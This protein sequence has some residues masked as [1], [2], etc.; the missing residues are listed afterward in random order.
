MPGSAPGFSDRG[1][2]VTKECRRQLYESI[3]KSL[4]RL[5]TEH[6]NDNPG[7][8]NTSA[9]YSRSGIDL[10]N[11]LA[12][13]AARH[14]PQIQL[15]PVDLS[16]A[17]TVACVSDGP[18]P[19]VKYYDISPEFLNL[20]RFSRED[21]ILQEPWT[22]PKTF[23]DKAHKELHAMYLKA[24][25][26]EEQ[27]ALVALARKDGSLCN[28][29]VSLIP[30]HHEPVQ[31]EDVETK[32]SRPIEWIVGFLAQEPETSVT[33]D[34][35]PAEHEQESCCASDLSDKSNTIHFVSSRGTVQYVSKSVEH[36]LGYTADEVVGR[37][38][39]EICHPNDMV[40]LMRELKD[41][42]N[43]RGPRRSLDGHEDVLSDL[44]LRRTAQPKLVH[45]NDTPTTQ[46]V[47][48]E[49]HGILRMNHK[50]STVIWME[51]VGRLV[52]QPS[53]S[54]RKN[55]TVVAVTGKPRE[56]VRKAAAEA[57]TAG[58]AAETATPLTDACPAPNHANVAP[59]AW[60]ALSA[61]G[62]ILQC[63][64]QNANGFQKA[65]SH[66][67]SELPVR[68]GYSLPSLMNKEAITAVQ[69]TIRQKFRPFCIAHWIGSTPV[70]TTWFPISPGAQMPELARLGASILVRLESQQ[71]GFDHVPNVI[72][73]PGPSHAVL[74]SDSAF[75]PEHSAH[76]FPQDDNSKMWWNTGDWSQ[77]IPAAEAPLAPRLAQ[78]PPLMATTGSPTV[79]IVAQSLV[80]DAF[81]MPVTTVAPESTLLMSPSTFS[82][83]Q[84]PGS[85][86]L[87]TTTV[88]TSIQMNNQSDFPL[89]STGVP[90]SVSLPHIPGTAAD[91]INSMSPHMMRNEAEGPVTDSAPMADVMSF[92]PYRL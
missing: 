12:R 13:V 38:V 7:H 41:L 76:D 27:K 92:W 39:E 54:G 50:H 6:S 40:A 86:A 46:M 20:Y 62:V 64:V 49:V 36:L 3:P 52:L 15:G 37:H 83:N 51:I 22:V 18:K 55:R 85:S 89:F 81:Q 71:M 63:V 75:A 17:M 57:T 11:I 88:P 26:G 14:L 82:V 43:S 66:N 29:F 53:G 72:F 65:R 31:D 16:C 73:E 58:V 34:E 59:P 74:P 68:V 19:I 91:S 30:L 10:V 84:N 35:T 79:P 24:V 9:L 33:V 70:A 2:N 67:E 69:G 78:V 77:S 56:Y 5:G 1:I 47:L 8:L 61:T 45:L 28:T 90:S 48:A 44:R 42:K 32:I 23:N 80:P 25:A 4:P 60:L 21:V 87:D